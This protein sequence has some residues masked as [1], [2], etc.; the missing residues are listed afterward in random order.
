MNV[1]VVCFDTLRADVAE[2]GYPRKLYTPNLDR[3]REESCVFGSVFAEGLPT[4][5]VRR[6]LF[7][8]MRS[9]PW[10]FEMDDR[11]SFP[12]CHGWHAMPPEQTTLAEILASH[13][14]L[15]GLVSDTYHM[16]KSTMNFVRGF[17]ST[18]YIRGQESDRWRVGPLADVD[19]TPYVEDSTASIEKLP[20]F[21]QYLLNVR[22]RATEE[23]YFVAKVFRRA[24]EFVA[25][26]SDQQPFFLWVDSFTPHEYWDPPKRFADR[27]FA[28]PKGV[29]DFIYPQMA[30]KPFDKFTAEE[31]ARTRALYLGY[32]SFADKWCGR[33]VDE[34]EERG[35]MKNTVL[36]VTADHGT[37]LFDKGRFG[38]SPEHL[39]AFNTRVPLF[40]RHPD[41]QFV[42]KRVDALVENHDLM[43]TILD[44]FGLNH[45]D[46]DGRSLWPLMLGK[47]KRHRDHVITGWGEYASV[48]TAQ[49]NLII[50]T[51]K[52]DAEPELYD[53][54]RDRGEMD[55]VARKR[56]G[57]RDALVRKLEDLLQAN[58]PVKLPHTW[59]NEHDVGF[60]QW[61]HAN[62]A[63]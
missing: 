52:R 59:T 62:V 35:L 5:P 21:A 31:I 37:E 27:Y 51:S 25:E 6:A 12:H 44:W 29:K 32:V 48:R 11:G 3:V 45:V 24:V 17:L 15:T 55:D 60:G 39:H 47:R 43:P 20:S 30:G 42:G 41:P 4:I 23:D 57:P 16:F 53:L 18:E 46:V 19:M 14:V 40:V 9:Y 36:V 56:K 50:R 63:K 22:S 10:R 61:M 28:A 8:G 13:G 26:A 38:K 1:V 54:G 49:Y 34:L 33:L 2:G 7:T 58:L